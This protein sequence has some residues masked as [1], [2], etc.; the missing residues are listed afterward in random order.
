MSLVTGITPL[1]HSVFFVRVPGNPGFLITVLQIKVFV[2]VKLGLPSHWNS[3]N[4][5]SC[6]YRRK[7]EGISASA[8]AH[9]KKGQLS[10]HQEIPYH[11]DFFVLY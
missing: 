5:L 6:G 1:H 7:T 11:W 3:V 8:N 2:V 10:P 4:P 9:R